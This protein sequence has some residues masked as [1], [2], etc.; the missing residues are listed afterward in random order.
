[1]AQNNYGLTIITVTCFLFTASIL[2]ELILKLKSLTLDKKLELTGLG[3]L[4]ILFGL[5][6]AYIH[7]LY[8]EW[9]LMLICAILIVLYSIHGF[10]K[11]KNIATVNNRL[12]NLILV[13]YLS[14]VGFTFSII[15]TMIMP[16]LSEPVGGV[17]IALLVVFIGGIIISKP[18]IINGEEVKTTDYLRKQAGHSVI[19]MTGY[20]LITLYTGLNM[21]G[22]LPSLYT[23][24]IPHAYIELINDAEAG[25][26]KPVDG[27]YKHELYKEA[28]DKFMQNQ[29][30]GD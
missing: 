4:F 14:L 10:R 18:Q 3:I 12:R 13:Y 2:L 26:E 20:L 28:Y 11:T 8:V 30:L 23:D 7:F 15:I 29:E 5:R 22:M 19:L 1:M 27:V 21:I 17:S 6:A 9:L 16:K 24:K 25:N